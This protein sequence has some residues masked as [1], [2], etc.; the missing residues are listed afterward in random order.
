M[1]IGEKEVKAL[2]HF[3]EMYYDEGRLHCK[4]V[5]CTGEG[6]LYSHLYDEDAFKVAQAFLN[7]KA[8]LFNIHMTQNTRKYH[9]F[10]CVMVDV[11]EVRK[12]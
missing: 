11:I 10:N 2:I 3:V 8:L 9:E 1:V 5:L 6:Y 4:C 12:L 7:S